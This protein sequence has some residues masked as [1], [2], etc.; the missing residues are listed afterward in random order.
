ML[1]NLTAEQQTFIRWLSLQPLVKQ[2][3]PSLQ[4]GIYRLTANEWVL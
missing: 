2:R 1:T 4:M 3:A